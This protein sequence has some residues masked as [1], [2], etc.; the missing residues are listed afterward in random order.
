MVAVKRGHFRIVRWCYKS[1]HAID[2]DVFVLL[3]RNGDCNTIK[4]LYKRCYTRLCIRPTT[5]STA[6]KKATANGHLKVLKFFYRTHNF[7]MTNCLRVAAKHGY[8]KLV[9][10]LFWLNNSE[11]KEAIFTAFHNK[12]YRVVEW[13]IKYSNLDYHT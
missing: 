2:R 5:S 12:H 8:L 4:Y 10:W 1:G 7:R 3:A 6:L 11:C 9:K 13:L